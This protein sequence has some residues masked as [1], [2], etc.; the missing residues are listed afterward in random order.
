MTVDAFLIFFCKRLS[1]HHATFSRHY[2][3]APNGHGTST[4]KSQ[5]SLRQKAEATSASECTFFCMETSGP[6]TLESGYLGILAIADSGH[7]DSRALA[8]YLIVSP[9]HWRLKNQRDGMSSFKELCCVVLCRVILYCVIVKIIEFEIEPIRR[10]SH[11]YRTS[12]TP[13]GATS[14]RARG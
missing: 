11:R 13:F 3:R 2:I 4:S 10:F 14:E 8:L 6:L 9:S 12:K 7:S 1:M 5:L